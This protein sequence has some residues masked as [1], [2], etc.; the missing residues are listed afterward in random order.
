[1]SCKC[2]YKNRPHPSQ[3]NPFFF[4]PLRQRHSDPLIEQQFYRLPHQLSIGPLD[5]R[6]ALAHTFPPP[7]TVLPFLV[8]A[9]VS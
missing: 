5:D 1:M 9:R 4:I 7:S 2:Q 6:L 3:F 8:P